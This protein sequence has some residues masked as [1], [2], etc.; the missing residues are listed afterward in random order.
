MALIKKVKGVSPVFGKD[1]YL[2]ENATVVGD[3]KIGD[4]CSIL[5]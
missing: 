2:E 3:V 4:Y 1:I 5:V